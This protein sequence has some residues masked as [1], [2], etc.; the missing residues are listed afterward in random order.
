MESEPSLEEK[1]NLF[2]DE[3]VED[4]GLMADDFPELGN[5]L[6]TYII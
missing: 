2:E 6:H 4:E 5:D 1:K 3:E